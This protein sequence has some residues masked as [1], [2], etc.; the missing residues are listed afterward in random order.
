MMTRE[1]EFAKEEMK[2]ELIEELPSDA[3]EISED[4]KCLLL[5]GLVE[6]EDAGDDVDVGGGD[7]DEIDELMD[8]DDEGGHDEHEEDEESDVKKEEEKGSQKQQLEKCIFWRDFDPEMGV[9]GEKWPRNALKTRKTSSFCGFHTSEVSILAW[10][11]HP[12]AVLL[13]KSAATTGK[14][15]FL[16]EFWDPDT[17][18]SL[19]NGD[20]WLKMLSDDFHC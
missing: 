10:E 20:F 5:N 17:W 19:R 8:H 1:A 7:D 15:Q 12:C 6:A 9:F 2:V 16:E 14:M 13:P 11:N 3:L 4:D 18:K